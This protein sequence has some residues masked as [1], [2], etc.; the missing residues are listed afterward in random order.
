MDRSLLTKMIGYRA[1]LIHGDTLVLDRWHWLKTRLPVTRNGEKLIDIG[2][3]TGAFSI[4]AALRGYETLGLSWDTRNQSVASERAEICKAESAR[5]EV[6]DV[7]NLDTR[8]D[9]IGKFDVAICCECIEH[10]IDDRKLLIDISSCL[11]PGGRLLL[12]T[13]YSLYRSITS[14][15]Q[16]PYSKTE[17]G[18]HVRRGYTK[19]MLDELC[20]HSDLVPERISYCS[21]IISQKVTM[22]L[23]TLD[24]IHP[25]FGWAIILPLRILPAVFDRLAT[26]LTK[27]PYYC[28][29]LEAYKERYTNTTPTPAGEQ[30]V[31]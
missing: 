1:T 5:F 28:I 18:W 16:G 12:T 22:I 14:K 21:G 8:G 7:R 11:K 30:N 29:C 19:A 13:P 25:L 15:D 6:L 9:L 27:W 23:R 26:T 3:G 24:R 2:C 10:I 20:R 17:D 4:G 31:V